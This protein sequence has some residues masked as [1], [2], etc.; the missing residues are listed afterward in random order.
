MVSS[1]EKIRDLILRVAQNS[2]GPTHL[3]GS[4]SSVEILAVLFTRIIDLTQDEN[5]PELSRDLF[6]LSK[7][8]CYL[9]LLATLSHIGRVDQSLLEG[10][11]SEK[12]PFGAHPVLGQTPDVISSNGS[13]GHGLGFGL[14]IS[15]QKR[16][17]GQS[18]T[19]YVLLGDG[20]CGEGSVY[21]AALLAPA[22][23]LENLVAII[24]SNSFGNDGG[25]PFGSIDKVHG[26]FSAFGWE[27][28]CVDGH[29][30]K[31]LCEAL[32]AP[33]PGKPL[34]VVAKTIKGKGLDG[35][36]GSNESHHMKL[37][38]ATAQRSS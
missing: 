7:G 34:L 10:Y 36:E 14:G 27:V 30:E 33:H 6:I 28:R 16:I 3:G 8:H 15:I 35:I 22:L 11:Q 26:A 20:E 12:S 23:Q 19:A 1:S 38:S 9:A 29:S 32:Q 18:G 17:D 24:D 21:E 25:L 13:L 37:S 5:H 2:P 31:A 4:L